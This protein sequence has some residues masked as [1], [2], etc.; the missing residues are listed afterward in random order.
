VRFGD[1][2]K[3]KT[4]SFL[5]KII[6]LIKVF[7]D[8]KSAA[9]KARLPALRGAIIIVLCKRKEIKVLQHSEKL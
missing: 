5:P 9:F 6:I 2:I 8:I 4:A 7:K 1:G 3:A